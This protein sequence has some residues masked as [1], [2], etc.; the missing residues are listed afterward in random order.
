MPLCLGRRSEYPVPEVKIAGSTFLGGW[1]LMISKPFV[2][3][4][5]VASYSEGNMGMVTPVGSLQ[6]EMDIKPIRMISW[7]STTVYG[8]LF[9]EGPAADC[10]PTFLMET[11]K[12]R[13]N[14]FWTSLILIFTDR[15]CGFHI[16]CW[17][18]ESTRDDRRKTPDFYKCYQLQ[19]VDMS[20]LYSFKLTKGLL[21]RLTIRKGPLLTLMAA[22]SMELAYTVWMAQE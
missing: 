10:K 1:I 17:D 21:D 4:H 12:M 8:F 7:Y 5:D 6:W 3:E 16:K 22:S 9:E 18:Y 13:V 19:E 11:R 14:G 20:W 15:C 2:F